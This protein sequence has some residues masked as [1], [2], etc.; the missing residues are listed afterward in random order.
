MATAT[1]TATIDSRS[2]TATATAK[3]AAPEKE[4]RPQLPPRSKRWWP[5]S[6]PRP[7]QAIFDLVLLGAFIA[8]QRSSTA[9]NFYSSLAARYSVFD[10]N[11][12]GAFGITTLVYWAVAGL[13]AIVD[14]THWPDIVFRYKVQPFEKVTIKEYAK[15]AKV[16]AKNQLFVVGPLLAGQAYLAPYPVEASAVPGSW[17]TLGYIAAS[18]AAIEVG[19]YYVH[20]TM[21]NPRLYARYHKQHHEF[22]APV[23]LA[24]TY[25]GVVEH[26]TSNL[27][28]NAIAMA[29]LRPHWSVATF[30]FC[31][32][33]I[34]TV[35]AHSGYNLPWARS[36]LRHDYHHFK[37]DVNYG[38]I[39]VLDA[40]HRT[41]T[42]YR[43]ALSDALARAKGDAGR[44]RSELLSRLAAWENGARE[45]EPAATKK[46]GPVGRGDSGS[47][48][49]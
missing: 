33:E 1:T 37:F 32:L 28:P 10:I 3:Q 22:T 34:S 49:D 24:A 15:I 8:W 18:I 44:A 40:I 29:L 11:A 31:F 5:V 19:F 4:Q 36:S 35:C 42:S 30:T 41:D 16:A 17:A 12:Y 13:F 14:L 48:S 9:H 39:G 47:D 43:A 23:G 26:L 2:A 7:T 38:P 25:C 45:D 20:K 21:H 6:N 46:V 27:A